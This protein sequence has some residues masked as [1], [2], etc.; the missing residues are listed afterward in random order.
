MKK[1]EYYNDNSL[2]NWFE[3][4]PILKFRYNWRATLLAKSAST[5]YEYIK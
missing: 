2:Q 4:E 1:L 5:M 3:H